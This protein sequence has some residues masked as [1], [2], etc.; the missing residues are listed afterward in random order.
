MTEHQGDVLLNRNDGADVLHPHPG[1]E[2]N[3]DDAESRTYVD[4]DTAHGLVATK[5]ARWCAHCGGGSD[6]SA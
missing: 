6:L 4:E 2:C 5:Q 1:E 3:T